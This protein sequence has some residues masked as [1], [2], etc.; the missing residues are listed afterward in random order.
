MRPPATPTVHAFLRCLMAASSP[1]CCSDFGIA[2]PLAGPPWNHNVIATVKANTENVRYM[3]FPFLIRLD[4]NG[5]QDF[6]W[7]MV[8]ARRMFR[9]ARSGSS[10]ILVVW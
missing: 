7:G 1:A 2:C 8:G 5:A 10:G 4:P 3:L 6:R 9:Q